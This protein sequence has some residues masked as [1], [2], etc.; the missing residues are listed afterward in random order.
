MPRRDRLAPGP[1]RRVFDMPAS[2]ERL[3]A[4]A[5]EGIEQVLVNGVPIRRDGRP[6]VDRLEA[7]P[8]EILRSVP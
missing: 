1:V 4:D 6:V 2:G 5:P 7:L 3:I 8:G